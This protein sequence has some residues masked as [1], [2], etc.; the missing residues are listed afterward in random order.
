M[1]TGK[2]YRELRARVPQE[3]LSLREALELLRELSQ[4]NFDAS[5][6]IAIRLGVNPRKAEE[7]LRGSCPAPAGLG[8]TVRILAF[9]N[10]DKVQEA[11][12]AGADIIGDDEI[13]A[14]IQDGWF[15][16][17]KIIATP[18]QMKSLARLGRVL[19]PKKLMPSPKDGTVTFE[20]G[21]AIGEM[22]A[23]KINFRVDRSGIVHA[24]IGK[25]SFD[26]E[27]LFKN[28]SALLD[29]LI[30]L[31]PATV[32]GRY[33]KSISVSTTMGPGIKIDARRVAEEISAV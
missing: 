1:A 22:K 5:A 31:R 13:V 8:R 17:D 23:G 18:D 19:G 16:F 33:I 7:N 25:R 30:R 11:R 20:V 32:K 4:E 29:N 3:A 12:D 10:A 15:E 27:A 21:K 14:K 9:V 2:K 24:V 6:E 28:A 26:T